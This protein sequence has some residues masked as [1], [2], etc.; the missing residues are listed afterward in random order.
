MS[1][2]NR[3]VLVLNNSFEAVNV[4][5]ARRGLT[6]VLGGKAVVEVPSEVSV[7]TARLKIQLPSVIRLLVYRRVP[8]PQH[9]AISR[10]KLL[11]RD[12][13]SCQYC[14]SP[15]L[16]KE[17][18]LDH[19]IPRSRGGESSWENLV[20]CCHRCNNRKGSRTPAE[21]G[22]TLRKKPARVGLHMTHRLMMTGAEDAA[23]EPYLFC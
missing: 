1:S 18:T 15:F 11:L 2:L 12:R 16:P 6:L 14:G 22:M 20:A 4:V 3:L 21:A 7:R 5:S 17:L 8:L 13:H 9:R 23:W 10:K 19:V